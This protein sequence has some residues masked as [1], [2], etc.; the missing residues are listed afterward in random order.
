MFVRV[1]VLDPIIFLLSVWK[2]DDISTCLRILNLFR[3]RWMVAL[4][5]P[6]HKLN[7]LFQQFK[8]LCLTFRLYE[9]IVISNMFVDFTDI[10]HNSFPKLNSYKESGFF[11]TFLFSIK[12]YRDD[13]RATRRKEVDMLLSRRV[14]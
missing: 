4:T 5:E 2:I 8:F 13:F 6:K 9:F 7:I 14:F 11:R 12:K 1:F 10:I 3:V